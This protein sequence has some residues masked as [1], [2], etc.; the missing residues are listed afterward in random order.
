MLIPRASPTILLTDSG[1]LFGFCDD[2]NEGRFQ[3]DD[4]FPL[5]NPITFRSDNQEM[6]AANLMGT[7]K[8]I[9]KGAESLTVV[10]SRAYPIYVL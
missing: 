6:A 4:P 9:R 8:N 10:T 1:V 7:R 3:T 5:R 2:L